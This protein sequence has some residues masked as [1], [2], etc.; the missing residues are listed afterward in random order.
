MDNPA[1]RD[2]ADFARVQYWYEG[3][4]RELRARSAY[5]LEKTL[6]PS[7][8]TTR[9]D[10][11]R[12]RNKW[13][14]YATGKHTPRQ[15][16]VDHVALLVPG[17]DRE[18]NH[19]L[20]RILQL[21]TVDSRMLD[22]WMSRLDFSVQQAVFFASD[23]AGAGGGHRPYCRW[24]GRRLVT[25]GSLDALACLVLY[26]YESPG[27]KAPRTVSPFGRIYDLLLIL[28]D[29]FLRRKVA[30]QVFDLFRCRVFERQTGGD[31]AFCLNAAHYLQSIVMLHRLLGAVRRVS[32]DSGRSVR[33][34]AMVDLLD[35]KMGFDV[36]F[37]LRLPWDPNWDLGPPRRQVLSDWERDCW[38]RTWGWSH[39]RAGTVGHFPGAGE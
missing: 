31:W 20:W 35:G 10:R 21:E 18:L 2:P 37:A 39:L 14:G 6:E 33:V 30:E 9:D 34:R 38:L 13:V 32:A 23:D 12:Y 16:L 1:D 27:S 8:F 11:T 5:R 4:R 29:E 22:R 19:P 7:S 36:K 24:L 25:L 26:S 17:S 15:R 28:G 3:L